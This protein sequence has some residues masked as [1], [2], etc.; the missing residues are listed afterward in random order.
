MIIVIWWIN[1]L[2]QM[3]IWTFRIPKI[4][5]SESW[6]HKRYSCFLTI[7][8]KIKDCPSPCHWY[9][10]QPFC[11]E[12]DWIRC[13][14]G[15]SGL[16]WKVV[17][18]VQ[19]YVSIRWFCTNLRTVLHLTIQNGTL[20]NIEMAKNL[21]KSGANLDLRDSHGRYSSKFKAIFQ[22]IEYVETLELFFIWLFKKKTLKR[23]YFWLNQVPIWTFR[24]LVEGSL[25]NLKLFFNF[26]IFF[27]TLELFSTWLFKMETLT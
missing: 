3:Q 1:W 10:I 4:G 11:A 20:K 12:I 15:P 5:M 17:F 19:S 18:K 2:N 14:S 26:L 25:R 23:Q 16:P 13:Q 24:T 9:W 8:L 21:I 7:V 22:F 6:H 27:K